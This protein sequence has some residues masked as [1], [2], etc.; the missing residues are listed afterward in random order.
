MKIFSFS[1]ITT[2]FA[3]ASSLVNAF[4]RQSNIESNSSNTITGDNF[5]SKESMLSSEKYYE[6]TA[7]LNTLNNS[8]NVW[9]DKISRFT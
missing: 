6:T 8:L 3:I 5:N 7:S 1:Y 2:S 9:Q 4:P